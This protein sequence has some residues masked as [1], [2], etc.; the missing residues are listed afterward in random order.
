MSHLLTH[1]RLYHRQGLCVIPTRRKRP[2]LHTWRPYTVRRPSDDDLCRW[3]T[4]D[5][6]DGLAVIC[7]DVSGG[8]VIRDFDD[9]R[10]YDRWL[11]DHYGLAGQLPTVKT[12]RGYHVY[13]RNGLR[14]I[15]K[16]GDGELRG[17]G[18][19]LLP[20]S[21][22]ESGTHYRWLVGLP[23]D[24]PVPEVDPFEVGLAPAPAEPPIPAPVL[25]LVSLGDTDGAIEEAIAMSLPQAPGQRNRQVFVLAR[26]LKTILG[27]DVDPETLRPIVQR[28]HSQ[29]LS[30]IR[31]KDFAATWRDFLY[32][33]PRVRVPLGI[34]PMS[35]AVAQAES[36]PLPAVA[37][38]YTC[39]VMRRL[40]GI[41]AALQAVSPELPFFLACRKAGDLLGVSYPVASRM[42]K[43]LVCDRVLHVARPPKRGRRRATRY[44]FQHLTERQ[45]NDNG[46][47]H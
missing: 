33:W 17:A 22:H 23:D 47:Q 16:L 27:S 35:A 40:I 41:C 45:N 26:I 13:L 21:L 20:P 43:R 2:T 18:Y 30:I 19:C 8:L 25:R 7:G 24:R 38:Q 12:G 14:S 5:R 32:G 34:R 10:T 39:P 1:A 42:L 4:S 46:K 44:R 3:F 29:A 9:E 37:Q 31:T 15:V 36:A 28:W 11:N 6:P